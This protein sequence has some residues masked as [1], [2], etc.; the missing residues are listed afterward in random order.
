MLAPSDK[1][2]NTD[3]SF[4]YWL[5]NAG[6]NDGITRKLIVLDE[7]AYNAL[8][9]NEVYLPANWKKDATNTTVEYYTPKQ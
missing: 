9:N 8:V 4:N 1:I 7:A 3:Y 2:E 6:T 5:D